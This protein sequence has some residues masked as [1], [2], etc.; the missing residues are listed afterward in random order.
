MAVRKTETRLPSWEMDPTVADP[1]KVS[2]SEL[3]QAVSSAKG[4]YHLVNFLSSPL[5]RGSRNDDVVEVAVK[6][7]SQTIPLSPMRQSVAGVPGNDLYATVLDELTALALEGARPAVPLKRAAETGDL[8]STTE[9]LIEAYRRVAA[10]LKLFA[11]PDGSL[12][13]RWLQTKPWAL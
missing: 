3:G 10:N 7:G 11:D 12:L 2:A 5:V 8:D 1:L 4:R 6:V 9:R 13:K